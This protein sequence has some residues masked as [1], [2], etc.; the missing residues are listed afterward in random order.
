MMRGM[1]GELLISGAFS[2]AG[3]ISGVWI[4]R[5]RS[6]RAD[7]Q[8]RQARRQ[9]LRLA[10]RLVELELCQGEVLLAEMARTRRY[11]RA[12]MRLPA[13]AWEEQRAVLATQL[14]AADWWQVRGAYEHIQRFN[15]ELD[16]RFAPSL[17]A[18]PESLEQAAVAAVIDVH[19]LRLTDTAPLRELW[20]TLRS[21]SWMLRA[22]LEEAES[23]HSA[24]ADDR[25]RAAELWPQLS[26]G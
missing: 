24:L 4:E 18:K 23:V 11:P 20:Q 1:M 17:Q 22:E 21:A 26:V 5:L 12:A 25:R 8:A 7:A 3:V 15:R 19:L 16:E 6:R 13:R 10:A 9:E 2:A 14:G